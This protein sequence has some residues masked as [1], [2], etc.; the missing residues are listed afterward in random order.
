MKHNLLV[1]L[2]FLIIIEA[3]CSV[4]HIAATPKK[5]HDRKDLSHSK[6]IL[7]DP[8]YSHLFDGSSLR[9]HNLASYEQ[10]PL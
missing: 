2:L 8:M 3:Y 4:H 7:N 6:V 5:I 10:V 9:R 1:F